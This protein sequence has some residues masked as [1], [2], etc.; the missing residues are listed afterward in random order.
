MRPPA[1]VIEFRP[2]TGAERSARRRFTRT[3]RAERV[4]RL[5]RDIEGLVPGSAKDIEE[6]LKALR[7]RLEARQIIALQPQLPLYTI[8][9]KASGRKPDQP[10]SD[11]R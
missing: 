6:T 5:L 4:G 1:K 10:A 7:H 11:G 8:K 9:G 2:P 3:K